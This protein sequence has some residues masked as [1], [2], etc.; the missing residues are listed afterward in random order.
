MTTP[1]HRAA[2][3]P[4]AYIAFVQICKGNSDDA[5]T[6]LEDEELVRRALKR[7]DELERALLAA[8]EAVGVADEELR[9]LRRLL[10]SLIDSLCL[11]GHE[12][13]RDDWEKACLQSGRYC[14]PFL[15]AHPA[16]V[17]VGERL[18]GASDCD[19]DGF[20]WFWDYGWTRQQRGWHDDEC[21]HWLPHWALPLP[22]AQ[23]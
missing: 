19:A 11:P 4:G 14:E 23:P 15:S 13:T 17:P 9:L 12:I 10:G 2:L 7:L 22:E 21:T 3:A 5:G 20:C 8:P 18:P 16:P 6:Y 1:D